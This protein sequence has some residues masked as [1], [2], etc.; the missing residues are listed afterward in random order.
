MGWL[1]NLEPGV[2][3]AGQDTYLFPGMS[4]SVTQYDKVTNAAGRTWALNPSSIDTTLQ[5]F[6]QTITYGGSSAYGGTFPTNRVS[7]CGNVN[8]FGV[9]APGNLPIQTSFVF[10]QGFVLVDANGVEYPIVV[11]LSLSQNFYLA[12]D[13]PYIT[14]SGDNGSELFCQPVILWLCTPPEGL[15]CYTWAGV[16]AAG[17]KISASLTGVRNDTPLGELCFPKPGIGN[18]NSALLPVASQ[19]SEQVWNTT[20]LMTGQSGSYSGVACTVFV[21][22][23][24]ER[25]VA[26][27][28]VGSSIG[29]QFFVDDVLVYTRAASGGTVVSGMAELEAIMAGINA[30][31]T[32]T[33][34]SLSSFSTD[35]IPALSQP[36]TCY[37]FTLTRNDGQTNA[38][39]LGFTSIWGY[40]LED[41]I[42][43]LGVVDSVP[44]VTLVGLQQTQNEVFLFDI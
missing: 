16:Q 32:Y 1:D 4:L 14:D 2:D 15:D 19:V 7:A 17:L 25:D 44:V 28:R 33:A 24:G 43:S 8:T 20:G 21:S 22:S 36:N 37:K 27:D 12:G 39:R 31:T 26:D 41:R 11:G 30:G 6:V 42:L 40:R 38:V 18:S 23:L 10:R 3:P 35:Y 13:T 5:G 34:T 29:D 9:F